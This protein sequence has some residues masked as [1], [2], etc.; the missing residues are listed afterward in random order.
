MR[1][2]TILFTIA[3]LVLCIIPAMASEYGSGTIEVSAPDGHAIANLYIVSNEGTTGTIIFQHQNGMTTGG[4]WS[5]TTVT[6]LYGYSIVRRGAIAIGP[7]FETRDYVTP[8]QLYTMFYQVPGVANMTEN[9]FSGFMDQSKVSLWP[10][11]ETD[12]PTS[13][14]IKVTITSDT[15]IEYWYDYVDTSTQQGLL[16]SS[17]D[18]WIKKIMEFAYGSFWLVYDF[19]TMLLYW[20]RFFFVDNFLLI[21]T[22]FLAV[23]MAFAAKN[24]RGNPEKFFRQYFKSI[25]GFVDFMLSMWRMLIETIGTVRGWFRI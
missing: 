6:D 10:A 19:V 12:S 22:L 9:R 17:T 16:A 14:V 4:A 2:L 23:P 8:G 20:L 3:L 24:S 1:K 15:E 5:Y 11:V 7:E 18:D 13:P 21:I 25:R